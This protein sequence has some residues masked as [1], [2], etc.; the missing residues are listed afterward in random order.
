VGAT[1]VTDTPN[2]AWLSLDEAAERL[3]VSR[4]RVREAIAAKAIAA[5]RDN[6]G[7]WRVSLPEGAAGVMRR[8]NETRPDPQQLVE[9]LFDEIE[10]LNGLMA[11]R[12]ANEERMSALIVRQQSALERAISCAE[13]SAD[14]KL[15]VERVATLNDRSQKLIERTLAKLEAQDADLSKMTGLLDRALATVAGLDA[16]VTRQSEVAIKQQALL[17]RTFAL[18]QRSLDRI[19]SSGTAPGLFRRLRDRMGGRA[20]RRGNP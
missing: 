1:P 2:D 8:I 9:M 11:E 7:F 4:L 13:R 16:E 6:H 12:A 18:V 19:G 17:E 5:R 15:D 10:E 3:G 20:S 14:P